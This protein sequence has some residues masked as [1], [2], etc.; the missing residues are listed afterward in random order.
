MKDETFLFGGISLFF[1]MC[2]AT[3]WWFSTEPAGTAAL[4]IACLMSAL[5]SFF[6]W[7][8]HHK[9]GSFPQEEKEAEVRHTAGLVAFFPP[10]SAYP[11]LAAFGTALLGL[12]AVYGLWLFL[13]GAGA[14]APGIWGFVFQYTDRRT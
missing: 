12:G 5:V 4:V 1:A 11:V 7:R 3:Y 13:I 6:F 8:Q 2:A 10:R 14:L 9:S